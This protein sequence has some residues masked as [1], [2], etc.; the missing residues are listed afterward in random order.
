M[1]GPGANGI[2]RAGA[3]IP[4]LSRLQLA[5]ICA[6]GAT[7]A[8]PSEE[9]LY[10]ALLFL[11]A[12]GFTKLTGT[13]EARGPEGAET[14][15]TLLRRYFGAVLDIIAAHGGDVLFFAGDAL[16]ALWPVAHGDEDALDYAA[17]RAAACALEVQERVHD[18]EATD[19]L[20]LQFRAVLAAGDLCAFEL[21]GVGGRWLQL[22]RGAPV[23][24]LRT[25]DRSALPGQ[26][27]A[28]ESLRVRLL[29]AGARVEARGDVLR[30]LHRVPYAPVPSKPAV[31]DELLP[32]LMHYVPEVV[33]DRLAAGQGDDMAE[34]RRVT[35]LFLSLLGGSAGVEPATDR[36]HAAV[37]RVQHT[38]A[39]FGG[40]VDQLLEDDKGASI[41]VAFGLPGASHDDDAVRAI[42]AARDLSEALHSLGLS[43]AAG[44]ATGQ[45][46]CCDHGADARRHYSLFGSPI[47]LAARLM[48]ESA[49]AGILCDEA[50]RSAA[51]ARIRFEPC[52]TTR[53]KGFAAD[54]DTYVPVQTLVA[55]R[56][57]DDALFGRGA[58]L[59]RLTDILTA[60]LVQPAGAFVAIEAD[61][62]MGK[63]TLVAAF[64]Q[65]IEDAPVDIAWGAADSLEAATPWYV[66]RDVV[67]HWF[68]ISRRMDPTLAC[69]RIL[70]GMDAWPELRSL[71]PLLDD[72][73]ALGIGESELTAQ[74]TGQVRADNLRRLLLH[75][76]RERARHQPLMLVIEDA[77]WVDA[78]SW[79]LLERLAAAEPRLLILLT[80]RPMAEPPEEYQELCAR[81]AAFALPLAALS[82][83]EC[84]RLM[85]RQLG[86]AA[87]APELVRI[88]HE[89]AE[90]NPFFTRELVRALADAGAFRVGGEVVE[91]E[92]TAALDRVPATLEGVI[93]ARIDAL[94]PGPQLTLKVASVLGRDFE[95]ELLRRAHPNA[96]THEQL[97]AELAELRR[98]ELVL[99]DAR[100]ARSA[101]SFVHALTH[102][103]TYSLLPF[104]RRQELHRAAAEALEAMH[105]DHEPIHARLAHHYRLARMPER[106]VPHLAGAGEQALNAYASRDT[107]R[108]LTDALELDHEVRG[109]LAVD[110]AR[111]RWCRFI[112]QAW[113]YQDDYVK[114]GEWF[115]RAV[116]YTGTRKRLGP[117]GAIGALAG[118]LA[119]G[120]VPRERP[121]RH[122]PAYDRLVEALRSIRELSAVHLW[123]ADK[124]SF[125]LSTINAARIARRIGASTESAY[126]IATYAYMLGLTALR[127]RAEREMRTAFAMAERVGELQQIAATGTVTGML[128]DQLGRIR[129]AVPFQQRA[130]EAAEALG[131]G[132]YRHRTLFQLAE[133]NLWRGEYAAAE[134]LY[135]RAIE[136]SLKA[137][138]HIAGL[139]HAMIALTL[140]RRG[141]VDGALAMLARPDAL[142][143]IRREAQALSLV[144]GL[145]VQAE[146]L[147]AAGDP[148]GAIDA[149]REAE[150]SI[151]S[152][153]DATSYY[154][155]IIGHSAIAQVRIDIGAPGDPEHDWPGSARRLDVAFRRLRKI[156]RLY[157]AGRA[158]YLLLTGRYHARERHVGRARK[159]LEQ[160]IVLA[161]RCGLPHELGHACRSLAALV[162][163]PRKVELLR[164]AA[165]V[166][167][168]T[169]QRLDLERTE[170]EL[171]FA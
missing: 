132:P 107:L 135:G 37:R 14:L 13:L 16:T 102:E 75:V 19:A 144:C 110:L 145:G 80:T 134:S 17:A 58:E 118:L 40:V 116:Q 4:Y 128:L 103:T 147:F 25:A 44:I 26:V 96:P 156:S 18:I 160:A 166:F 73:L 130:L 24:E 46:F 104:A 23:H 33:A 87:I 117:A 52:G 105:P 31:P 34:F 9:S 6:A 84:A 138:P 83:E 5:R 77:H 98:A 62:G 93:T 109:P 164:R 41:I 119:G 123:N 151:T 70:A 82:S 61:A 169:G 49:V 127:G 125:A 165:D 64:V 91:F 122:D 20:K 85:A 63:S 56:S 140:L 43:P 21:G 111:A 146:A 95:D 126:A 65:A 113:Y 27:V 114:A 8:A 162:T 32:A 92:E 22:V 86:T 133:T 139:A 108:F 171:R 152:A 153:D 131:A 99:A 39:R 67:R 148:Q 129:E 47:N 29:R 170:L 54:V 15:A 45:V 100:G 11:D 112:A 2:E 55:A 161:D 71:T 88:V 142:P 60:H 66:F 28:P 149:V 68:G 89:R 106:A 1:N 141:D 42:A 115:E 157:P 78:A 48:Q 81:A 101:H 94:A 3:V 79:A 36:L 97:E 72:V 38:A 121:G 90:G 155:G 51:A 30:A 168:R 53:P 69:R 7:P 137:E 143:L 136:A 120:A 154:T 124:A 159:A 57:L 50:T 12:A 10:G 59:H 76:A 163:G 35:V 150:N 167:A 74:M 158:R